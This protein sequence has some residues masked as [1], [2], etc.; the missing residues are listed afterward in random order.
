MKKIVCLI[1]VFIIISS[2]CCVGTFAEES[3]VHSKYEQYCYDTL[4]ALDIL[5]EDEELGNRVTKGQFCDIVVKMLK[6]DG[7]YNEKTLYFRDVPTEHEYYNSISILAR[8]GYLFGDETQRIY[9]DEY[10]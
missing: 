6:L 10:I 7:T 1:M 5:S 3:T 9:P 4:V 8:Q 2:I